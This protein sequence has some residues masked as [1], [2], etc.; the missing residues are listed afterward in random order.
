M[1][2]N[3]L[4]SVRKYVGHNK[5]L[6]V[7]SWILLY[8]ELGQVLM[9]YRSDFKAWDFPGGTLELGETI[10]DCA[11]RELKEETN[12]EVDEFKFLDIFSGEDTFRVYP[13]GDQ[14]YV[15]TVLMEAHNPRG[16]LKINDGE[17]YELKWFDVDKIPDNLAPV[18]KVL[19]KGVKK[20]L[21][22]DINE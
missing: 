22:G 9:Q 14:L 19:F 17:S 1:E 18:T 8:N 6:T 12:L 13:N 2:E 21:R 4:K 3:Y 7:G 15:F 11:R 20:H 16:E 5:L 10:E